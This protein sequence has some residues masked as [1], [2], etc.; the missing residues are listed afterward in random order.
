[1]KV[2]AV[3]FGNVADVEGAD[4]QIHERD[5]AAVSDSERHLP[6]PEEKLRQPRNKNAGTHDEQVELPAQREKTLYL[7]QGYGGKILQPFQRERKHGPH[8]VRGKNPDALLA[9]L[10]KNF[11]SPQLILVGQTAQEAL[12]RRASVNMAK[13]GRRRFMTLQQ[14]IQRLHPRRAFLRRRKAS[15][16]GGGFK[17]GQLHQHL[18][19]PVTAE[20]IPQKR[21]RFRAVLPVRCLLPH[22]SLLMTC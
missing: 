10:K 21:A 16:S 19:A 17:S 18:G 11:Q 14:R 3:V 1:M 5:F 9:H 4:K 15:A 2:R 7:R 22:M 12:E 6:G 8:I 13:K 20:K